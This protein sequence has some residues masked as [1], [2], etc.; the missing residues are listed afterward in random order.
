MKG[1][2]SE[3]QISREKCLLEAEPYILSQL[4]FQCMWWSSFVGILMCLEKMG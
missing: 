1:G 3:I 4:P 2:V